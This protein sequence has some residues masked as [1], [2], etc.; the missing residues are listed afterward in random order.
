M[1]TIPENRLSASNCAVLA[2]QSFLVPLRLLSDAKTSQAALDKLRQAFEEVKRWVPTLANTIAG[3]NLVAL[4]EPMPPRFSRLDV[5]RYSKGHR[6]FLTFA[7]RCPIPAGQDL[8]A[9][10]RLISA[11]YDHLVEL[12]ATFK[13]LSGIGLFLDKALLDQQKEDLEEPGMFSRGHD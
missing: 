12:A 10:V 5:L 9:R 1:A 3:A 6:L 2:S 7:L 11:V 13:E 4:E 8:W